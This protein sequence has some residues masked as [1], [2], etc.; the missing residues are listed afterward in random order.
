MRTHFSLLSALL[1]AGTIPTLRAE[2][3]YSV[4]ALGSLSG[5]D[6]T[7]GYALN[8][9][10]QVTGASVVASGIQFHAFLYSDGQM[11][12]LGIGDGSVGRGINNG[13]QVTGDFSMPSGAI[14]AF[15][16]T[17]GQIQDLG[18][19]GGLYSRGYGLNNQG[20]VAG[21]SYTSSNVSHA[22]LYTNG[23]MQD[24]GTLG[25]LN[26]FGYGINNQG[27]VVGNAYDPSGSSLA[28]VYDGGR[29]QNLNS[30]I[31]PILGITL[32]SASAIN[33]NG[34]IVASSVSGTR[35]YLLTPVPEPGTWALLGAGLLGL[36]GWAQGGAGPRAAWRFA[37]ELRSSS[38]VR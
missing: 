23:Q 27:Q 19:L 32:S 8:N 36:L 16:Y 17:N 37:Q 34:Q 4:T 28:F 1:L 15:L 30:L 31:D 18:T 38:R 14:H 24:L 21:N 35:T 26:S 7:Y 25:G 9:G 6:I 10:G 5:Y 3:L 13:G 2:V 22:F 29:L 12:D 11:R 33:D 20:Q